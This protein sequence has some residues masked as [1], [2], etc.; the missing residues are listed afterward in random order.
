ML[1]PADSQECSDFT[2]LAFQ[3]SERFDT[4]VLVRSETRV[5]HSDSP[6]ELGE[7]EKPSV[8]KELDRK[9]VAK[10]VM[11]PA[12]ARVRRVLVEERT[13]GLSSYADHEFPFN[14]IEI[15][16]PSVGF[17]SHYCGRA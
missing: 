4:P 3:I 10:H 6:V 12:H 16:D 9:Q 15:N 17:N 5:S 11:V 13:A 2:R 14:T 7:R 8:E 1:E